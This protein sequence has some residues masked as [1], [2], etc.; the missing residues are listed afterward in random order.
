MNF[1]NNAT[2]IRRELLIK[3]IRLFDANKLTSDID[4]IPI[5]MF[6]KRASSV[7]CCIHKDRAVLKYRLMALLGHRIEAETDELKPLSDYTQ[8]A[9]G[10]SKVDGPVLTVLDDACSGCVRNNYFI[11]NA[12]RGCVARPC[13]MNCPK[14]AIRMVE[15]Q[16]RID[17]DACVNCG[18]CMTVCPYHAVI[19]QPIPCEEACPVGAIHKDE[20]GKEQIDD[21]KCIHCGKCM[22]ACPFGA[23]M[24]RSQCVDILHAMQSDRR[25]VAMLAPA[26]VGQ[27]KADYGRIVDAVYRLGF[28]D[29]VEVALGAEET[30]RRESA[31]FLERMERGDALMTTS[32]CPAYTETVEKHLPDLKPSVSNTRSPMHY[33]AERISR[34]DPDAVK[35]FIGPCVAKRNE[36]L[37][38]PLVDF[39][40]TFEEMGACMVARGVDVNECEA[41]EF[42]TPAGRGGRGF[43]L[44]GGVTEA[45]RRT[46]GDTEP[47]EPVVVDGLNKS[48]LRVLKNCSKGRCDGNFVEVMSCEGGCMAGP[49]VLGNV[50]L[51]Q[52][53][54]KTVLEQSGAE[55]EEPVT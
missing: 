40:M 21:D 48:T 47:L 42:E 26:A 12:C 31:E 24:E 46:V 45:I 7:R 53:Q 50:K 41:R 17:E 16:A 25:V 54:L 23:V 10:R 20:D 39:V 22:T 32:C 30:A 38:D 52:R 51:G 28:D 11:T 8:D 55:V 4:R 37:R 3:L 18:K 34:E 49:A 36:A 2:L 6:P 43:P 13:L 14:D 15:G 35:V 33:T 9:L 27:F 29:V 5:E 44:S 1:V 19:Y